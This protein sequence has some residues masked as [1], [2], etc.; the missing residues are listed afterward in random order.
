[1]VERATPYFD[2]RRF[3]LFQ[4]DLVS[5]S[6]FDGELLTASLRLENDCVLDVAAHQARNELFRLAMSNQKL[7]SNALQIRP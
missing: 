6:L 7:A 3:V 2:E 5:D 1:M 4:L